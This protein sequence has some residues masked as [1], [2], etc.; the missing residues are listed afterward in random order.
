ME[1]GLL[2]LFTGRNLINLE[3]TASTNNFA[4]E[5]LANNEPI[6][7]T[8]ILAEYQRYGKGQR[9]NSWISEYGSN[10]LVSYIFYP[11]F[12]FSKDH[13]YLNFVMS[14]A[15]AKTI[16]SFGVQDVLIKWPNDIYAANRKIAGML[17]ENTVKGNTIF[18]TVLGFGININQ[19]EFPDFTAKATSLNLE[20]GKEFN[21]I[22]I[23]E[24]LSNHLEKYYLN[25]K[26]GNFKV[27]MDEYT[28]IL[29]R[30]NK[31]HTYE[32]DGK[33]FIGKIVNVAEDGNLI[34]EKANGETRDYR[35]KEIKFLI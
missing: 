16:I 5:M 24:V 32:S 26:K 20:T 29:Y 18:S 17:A 25:L 30:K 9:G 2:T 14:L 35:F 11:K 19:C 27:I 8:A 7:G 6:E 23:F 4:S 13:F 10:L 21:K 28:D 12:L 15:C 3:T 33:I 1:K 34:I 31:L 22:E